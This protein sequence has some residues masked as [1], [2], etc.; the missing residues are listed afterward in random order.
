MIKRNLNI[1]LE[2]ILLWSRLSNIHNYTII[3]VQ[4]IWKHTRSKKK[5]E[6]WKKLNKKKKKTIKKFIDQKRKENSYQEKIVNLNS[7]EK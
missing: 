3:K 2:C 7:G 6:K 5:N 4:Y 1:P